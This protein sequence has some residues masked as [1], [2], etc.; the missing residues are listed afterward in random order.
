LVAG[1]AKLIWLRLGRAKPFVVKNLGFI[2][3]HPRLLRTSRVNLWLKLPYPLQLC[4][5]R[6]GFNRKLRTDGD[7]A[8]SIFDWAEE[9]LGFIQK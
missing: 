6:V 9:L 3:V 5:S 2:R 7:I 8:Q 4:V 1:T